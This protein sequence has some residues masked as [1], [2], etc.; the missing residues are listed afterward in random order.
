VTGSN[1][2]GSLVQLRCLQSWCALLAVL[3]CPS[4]LG[5]AQ[6]QVQYF[7]DKEKSTLAL[8]DLQFASPTRGAAVGVIL[9]GSH[10]SPVAM[11]TSDGGVHW[12]TIQLKEIPVSLFFLNDNFGWMVTEKGLWQTTEAGKNW[13]KLPKLPAPANRVYFADE[14]TGWAV[15]LKKTVLETHNGGETW[16]PV[17]AAAEQPGSKENSI[18]NW[19]AFATPQFGMIVGFNQPPQRMFQQFPAW[20]DPEDALSHRDTPHLSYT[21]VTKD[22]G[23]TWKSSAASLFGN[24]TRVRFGPHGVGVGLI[25]YSESFRYPSEAY[26]IEWTT[27]KSASIFHDKRFAI[28]DTWIASDG[29]V[30][31][32]G[33][34]VPGE[35][36][37]VIPGRVQVLKSK[38]LS[39]WT[40]MEVDYRAVARQVTFS[41][42]ND[43]NLWIATDNGMI[44]KLK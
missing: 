11:V 38:D 1:A 40:E 23:K 14:K 29:T 10:R 25:E 21:L 4:P 35:L 32:A 6:W 26:K 37:T 7:Y 44:L 18:F 22:G 41:A 28:S 30:Y 39:A 27:G 19:I 2:A 8:N 24:V 15:C 17:P 5:A 16:T 33:I 43:D 9:E 3:A 13:R 20:L 12:D 42:P 36:R 31:L 34:A